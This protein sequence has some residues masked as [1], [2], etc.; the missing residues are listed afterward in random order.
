MP[1]LPQVVNVAPGSISYVRLWDYVY[2]LGMSYSAFDGVYNWAAA[3]VDY[4]AGPAVVQLTCKGPYPGEKLRK[5]FEDGGMTIT[6]I[7]PPNAPIPVNVPVFYVSA[8]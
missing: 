5:V 4:T 1:Y 8:V 7:N 6:I 3:A 2:K